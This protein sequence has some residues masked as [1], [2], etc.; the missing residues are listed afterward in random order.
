MLLL[1]MIGAF[2]AAC[3]LGAFWL[4]IPVL[5]LISGCDLEEYR[6]L[7][8]VLMVGGGVNSATFFMY[9]ILTIMRKAK[10]ILIGYSSAALITLITSNYLVKSIGLVGAA[11]SFVITVLYLFAFFLLCYGKTMRNN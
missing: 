1:G 4:G 8:V 2:T 10:S 7:L 3:M 9:Y 5:S 11:Y 6:M